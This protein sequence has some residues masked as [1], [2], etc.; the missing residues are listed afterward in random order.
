M[1]QRTLPRTR[2]TREQTRA[3]LLAAAGTVFD[4]GGYQSTSLDDVAETAGL[5]KGAIY[6]NFGSKDDL[7]AAL[8]STRIR[9][10]LDRVTEEVGDQDS[11]DALAR[12]AGKA[13]TDATLGDPEWHV[14][15]LEF[16]TRAMH[17]EAVRE[18]FAAGRATSRRII[19]QYLAEQATRGNIVLPLEPDRL[20]TAILALSNGLAIEHLLDAD[21]DR[22][23]LPDLL[24]MILAPRT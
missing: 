1:T 19:S 17:N 18:A 24:R 20:A 5:T 14:A 7:F 11:A 16:W 12:G 6:S 9:E 21:P 15:F 4:A 3:R 8:M 23:L 2:P 22:E 10:R 13:L